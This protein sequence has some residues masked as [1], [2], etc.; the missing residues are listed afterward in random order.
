M[1]DSCFKTQI[2]PNKIII[3][4]VDD[5]LKRNGDLSGIL[6]QWNHKV[7]WRRTLG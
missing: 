2:I 1:Q 4:H 7:T 5:Y 3:R 6:T